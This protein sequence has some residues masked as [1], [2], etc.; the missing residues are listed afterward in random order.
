M[1]FYTHNDDPEWREATIHNIDTGITY[2][3]ELQSFNGVR[4]PV[5]EMIAPEATALQGKRLFKGEQ[6]VEFWRALLFRNPWNGSPTSPRHF[7]DELVGRNESELE[8]GTPF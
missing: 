8:E 6:A 7:L 4:T 3:L 2:K 5:V 1:L